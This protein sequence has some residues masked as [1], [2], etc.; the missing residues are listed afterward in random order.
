MVKVPVTM[1]FARTA[2]AA[3]AADWHALKGALEE[4]MPDGFQI[5]TLPPGAII[6]EVS[7]LGVTADLPDGT[8]KHIQ[9]GLDSFG[10]LFV[11]TT[12]IDARNVTISIGKPEPQP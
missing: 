6:K 8:T 11:E 9:V 4:A 7:P 1:E 12:I 3:E 10:Q 2:K 5:G